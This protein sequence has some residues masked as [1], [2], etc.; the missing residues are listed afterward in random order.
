M[1]AIRSEA[2]RAGRYPL[3][4]DCCSKERR[5]ETM[6]GPNEKEVGE[7]ALRSSFADRNMADGVEFNRTGHQRLSGSNRVA[8]RKADA[9]RGHFGSEKI[10]NDFAIT[11][12]D[13]G[14]YP[15]GHSPVGRHEHT[16]C[17]ATGA[18]ARSRAA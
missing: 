14:R 3:G 2:G 7:R 18:R 15:G 8:N 6:D 5:F 12:G 17:A 16:G 9:N 10:R 13:F 4:H 1:Q 11:G